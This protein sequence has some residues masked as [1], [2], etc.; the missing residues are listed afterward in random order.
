MTLLTSLFCTSHTASMNHHF[1]VAHIS[2]L[3]TRPTWLSHS[4]VHACLSYQLKGMCNYQ[5]SHQHPFSIPHTLPTWPPLFGYPHN[6]PKLRC[7]N[8]LP[9]TSLSLLHTLPTW[10]S[11]SVT[12]T[13]AYSSYQLK[14]VCNFFF[15]YP[16]DIPFLFF[17]HCLMTI[18]FCSVGFVAFIISS[19]VCISFISSPINPLTS[20]FYTSH[21]A[22]MTI[23]FLLPTLPTTAQ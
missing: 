2:L 23:T 15:N 1:L 11:F 10:I 6:L 18:N 21:T 5:L 17:T 12:C 7:I 9:P 20:L 8:V 19:R 16:T 3:H 13:T 4:V 14:G 22:Y